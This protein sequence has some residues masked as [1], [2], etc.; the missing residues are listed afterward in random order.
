MSFEAHLSKHFTLTEL[1]HTST[2][3]PNKPT[4]EAINH[5]KLLCENVLEPVRDHF[6]RPVIIS[7]G[8]RSLAVNRAVKSGDT[9]QHIKGE[10]ADFHVQ[11]Y[12]VYELAIWINEN[13]DFDQLILE[14]FVPSKKY[15]GWVH[16]SYGPRMR[17]SEMTKFRGSSKYYAGINLTPEKVR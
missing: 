14:N 16:C 8:Y 12:T 11:G 4:S 15:S 5:L 2:G 13:L 10:A 6:R 3:L 17:N 7:S 1:T 9:S